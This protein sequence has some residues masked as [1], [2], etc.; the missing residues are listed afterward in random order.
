MEFWEDILVYTWW[1]KDLKLNEYKKR[2]KGRCS[3]WLLLWAILIVS[4]IP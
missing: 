2:E 4:L 1:E 3:C